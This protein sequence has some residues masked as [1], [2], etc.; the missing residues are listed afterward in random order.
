MEFKTESGT[1][2]YEEYGQ[3]ELVVLLH[4]FT[5]SHHTW[6]R[7]LNKMKSGSRT[8]VLDMPGHGQTR[9]QQVTMGKFCDDLRALLDHVGCTDCHLI[10]YSMGGRA[11]LSF[12]SRFPHLVRS[13]VLE[14]AS[15]GLKTEEE[16]KIRR[17]Q[18][19]KLAD[20]IEKTGVAAFVRHWENIPLFATQ[21]MLPQDIQQRIRDERL[22]QSAQGLA[23][24][25]R[26]MGTGEQE[27]VWGRLR[28]LKMP[29]LLI[30]G[31]KDEKF[32][33][34]NQRMHSLLPHS[35]ICEIPGCGHAIHVE[36]P[37]VFDKLVVEFVKRL[38]HTGE[39]SQEGGNK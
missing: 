22:S 28:A 37:E 23:D 14:S 2:Y 29:V 6:D 34:I 3:G 20:Q 36:N 8:I 13:L 12:A 10:G 5:G 31:S 4:G 15:P 35:E 33:K 30:T 16:R 7:L 32:V 1:Y 17:L 39:P 21:T 26:F 27:P 38:I 19:H 25:L 9:T 24:S 18:D 11:A